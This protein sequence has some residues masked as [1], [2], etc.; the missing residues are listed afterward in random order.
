MH[1]ILHFLPFLIG[2]ALIVSLVF[3]LGCWYTRRQWDDVSDQDGP[4]PGRR[5]ETDPR[6]ARWSNR[7]SIY[8]DVQL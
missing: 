5:H 2:A 8:T 6:K 3:L 1:A 7:P 4:L